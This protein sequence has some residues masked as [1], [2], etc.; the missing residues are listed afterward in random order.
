MTEPPLDDHGLRGAPVGTA[1]RTMRTRA[2][3][4]QAELSRAASMNP[5]TIRQAE[6]DGHSVK[7]LTRNKIANAFNALASEQHQ[8]SVDELFPP[9]SR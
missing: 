5:A 4:S 9:L 8:T 1:L 2:G 6:A 7:E 3:I